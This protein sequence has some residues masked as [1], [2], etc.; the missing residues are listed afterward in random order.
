M[1]LTSCN[2]KFSTFTLSMTAKIACSNSVVEESGSSV[3]FPDIYKVY[4]QN[5]RLEPSAADNLHREHVKYLLKD[6]KLILV[7]DLDHTLVN[8]VFNDQITEEE[9][10]LLDEIMMIEGKT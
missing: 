4:L 10:Y 3:A 9:E 1:N 7:L 2:F 6:K 5:L 8:S